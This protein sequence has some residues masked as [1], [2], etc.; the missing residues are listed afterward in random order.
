[1]WE[2]V[3]HLVPQ[4]LNRRQQLGADLLVALAPAARA[5]G[6][7]GT[8]ET[9]LY[10]PGFED[11]DYRVPDLLFSGPEQRKHRGVPGGAEL[12]IEIRSPGD[13]SDAKVPFYVE[14]GRQEILNVDRDTLRMDLCAQ[15]ERLPAADGYNLA[16]LGVRI[17][18]I[19]G[20]ERLAVTW[21]GETAVIT[22]FTG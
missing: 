6:L 19:S 3:L 13:E 15:G 7:I 8:Y 18:R 5:R 4:P 21:Q 2:G 11:S 1:M 10:R 22:P 12:V 16:S 20:P 17:E 14:M 9:Q